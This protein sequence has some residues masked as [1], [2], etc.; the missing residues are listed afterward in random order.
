MQTLLLLDEPVDSFRDL[1]AT[2]SRPAEFTTRYELGG[3]PVFQHQA[4]AVRI[5][6]LV[7][8]SPSDADSL[9]RDYFAQRR[10]GTQHSITRPPP[11][12]RMVT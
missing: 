8:L 4:M 5:R 10:R 11:M 1:A 12:G 2:W 7:K 9:W 3:N 6:A